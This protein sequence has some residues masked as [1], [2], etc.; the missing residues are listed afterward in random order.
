MFMNTETAGVRYLNPTSSASSAH[1]QEAYASRSPARVKTARVLHVINGEHYSGAERVQDLLALRLG[2]FGYEVGFACVKPDKFLE[3]RQS[4]AAAVHET[5]MTNKFDVRVARRL[6]KLVR[7]HDY[8]LIHAHTPRTAMVGRIAAACAGVPLVY[9][10]HS[11]TS[12]DSTRGFAN[13]V[14]A[15]IER[16]SASGAA[17]LIC[18]SQSLG[19]HMLAEG[20][21][22]SRMAVVPN[23]VPAIDD[24]PPRST[25]SGEWT[26]GTVAL[27][28]PRKGTEVLIDALA[29]L[30]EQKLPARLRCVGGFETA[31]YERQLKDRVAKHALDKFVDWTG[32]T[33]N[34]NGELKQMDLFALPSLFG[35]GLPMVVLEAMATGVPVVATD[36]EGVPEAIRDGV[37]GVIARACDAEDLAEKI[38]RVL[39]GDLDWQGLR[40]SA[41]ERQRAMF[42]DRSMAAGVAKVYDELT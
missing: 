34:V 22:K 10:V 17:K 30:R 27:F 1:I 28:R 7:E 33:R 6:V 12:R 37:D 24:V 26:I 42:S 9:H 14:N 19:R 2:E 29:I 16:A 21:S 13:R 11:P 25:P 20:F 23:G 38:A 15:W 41:L 35:E 5:P 39:R 32:F 40:S 18:V 8:Q 36:V 3:S 4:Q 31:E